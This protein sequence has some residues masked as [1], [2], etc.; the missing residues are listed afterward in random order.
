MKEILIS[1]LNMPNE[2]Y[3]RYQMLEYIKEKADRVLV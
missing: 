1:K 2:E 3:G